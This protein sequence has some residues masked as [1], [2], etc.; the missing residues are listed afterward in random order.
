M[1]RILVALHETRWLWM[2]LIS[3]SELS[4]S[5]RSGTTVDVCAASAPI[6]RAAANDRA[7]KRRPVVDRLLC[8]LRKSGA[9]EGARTL[10]PD[11]GKVVLYH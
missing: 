9:G 4:P 8:Q 6:V 7:A 10:D 3:A 5:E 2:R 1:E 11:L